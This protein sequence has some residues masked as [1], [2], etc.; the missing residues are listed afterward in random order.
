[1]TT[2]KTKPITPAMRTVE[3]LSIED[4]SNSNY[5]L[6]FSS[7]KDERAEQFAWVAEGLAGLYAHYNRVYFGGRLPTFRIVAAEPKTF[8]ITGTYE[9]ESSTIYVYLTDRIWIELLRETL[10]HEMVHVSIASG[11]HD[12]RFRAEL[13]RVA[14]MGHEDAAYDDWTKSEGWNGTFRS[15][16]EKDRWEARLERSSEWGSPDFIDDNGDFVVKEEDDPYLRRVE[17]RGHVAAQPV[18][19]G[20]RP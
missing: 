16:E 13:H 9:E 1:M 12:E 20:A 7:Q 15:A 3:E 6:G 4:L 5:R 2:T 11:E 19:S 14:E 18:P 8:F 10:I 17:V